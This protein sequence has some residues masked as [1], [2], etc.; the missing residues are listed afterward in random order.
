[1]AAADVPRHAVREVGHV[2]RRANAQVLIRYIHL[3]GFVDPGPGV[4]L[5]IIFKKGWYMRTI[6]LA[7]A[8]IVLVV[9]L[10][11]GSAAAKGSADAKVLTRWDGTWKHHTVVKPAAW[12][13]VSGEI[14]GAT[15]GE[16]I[17]GGQYHQISGRT[18]TTETRE[19]QRFE[20]RSG[21]YQKWAFDS[22]GGQSFWVGTWDETSETMTW[23]YMDFGLGMEGKIVDRFTGADRYET[24]LVLKDSQGNVLLNIRSKHT[25]FAGGP[26]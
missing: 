13:P 20:L 9:I 12:S 16:W 10:A 7:S 22:T 17:L 8:A 23:K 14:P 19:I 25:R 15:T 4:A 11:A 5:M 24:T 3:D 26:E 18:G 21:Q 1:M 2:S 6:Y